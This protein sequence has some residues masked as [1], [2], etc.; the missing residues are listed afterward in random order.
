[1]REFLTVVGILVL[2][3]TAYAVNEATQDKIYSWR[4]KMT[5][6]VETPEGVKTGSA[7]REV[8]EK[9]KYAPHLGKDFPYRIKRDV[10]GEAVVVDL[11]ERGKVFALLKGYW[12]G[13][14]HAVLITNYAIPR[15][16]EYEERSAEYYDTLKDVEIVL[17]PYQYPMFVTFTDLS[18]PKTVVPLLAYEKSN[19][20]ENW[21]VKGSNFEKNFGGGVKLKSVTIEMTDEKVTEEALKHLPSFGK[22]TG[23]LDWLKTLKYGDFKY[24]S[25]SDYKKENVYV[26]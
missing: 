5:V 21:A 17:N 19:R 14:D 10:K 16:K 18:D 15:P 2:A 22:E 23:F 9:F 6:E 20:P 7:V 4:Y 13:V 26:D 25:P 11:G 1:M 24:I 3:S 12:L 8:V